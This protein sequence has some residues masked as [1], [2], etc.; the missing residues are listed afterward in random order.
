MN[1]VALT[2]TQLA[3]L[4]AAATQTQGRLERFPSNVN[5]GA[6][7]KVVRALLLADLVVADGAHHWLTDA[8]YAAVGLDPPSAPAASEPVDP[9]DAVEED[10]PVSTTPAPRTRDNSKQAQIRALL[11]RPEGATLAQIC[12]ATGWQK[13]TVRGTFAGVFK[14]KLRLNLV[15][16]KV[17][18]ERVYRIAAAPQRATRD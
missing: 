11:E 3:V 14:K 13:H 4:I 2:D 9:D 12:E 1:D 6:R 10:P 18:G 7:A 16:E 5:G 15:S 17:Q 8:G